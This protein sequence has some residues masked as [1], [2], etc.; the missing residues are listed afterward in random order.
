MQ[1]LRRFVTG[2]LI[3][4]IVVI[5]IPLIAV[6]I[7]CRPF[8]A[9]DPEA[10][11][12]ADNSS[13][14][15]PAI[16]Q[17]KADLS[18]YTRPE[19]QTY[20]TLPEWYIVYSTDEYAVFI[21][22]KLPSRFP[23]FQAIGQ[24]WRSYYEVCGV[25]RTQQYP[26]NTGYHLSLV[27][28][29][30]SF[31]LENTFK[32]LY[33]STVGRFTERISSPAL[34][35]EDF[36]AR[37]VAKEYG[38]FIHTIPW[39]EFPFAARVRQLWQETSLWGPN[40]IRKWERKLALSFEYGVKSGYGWLIKKGTGAAYTPE[41]LLIQAW[42]EG[43]TATILQQYPDFQVVKPISET[44]A[45]VSIPR[46]EAFTQLL[47]KLTDQGVRFVEIAG[48]DEILITAFA[49]S[50]WTYNLDAGTFLFA[51]PVP[52]QPTR[53][54]IAVNVPVSALHRVLADLEKQGIRL[55]HIYDY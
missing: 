4:V 54:R 51:L 10:T 5:V 27:V 38:D 32:G 37:Q 42:A 30:A 22:D 49:P 50:T 2:V 31:T 36:Y 52:T 40:P 26:F 9:P 15:S 13:A 25:T 29:G 34:T 23:Y 20:L 1:R 11:V 7:A 16:Q 41:K 44:V 24:Y 17:I 35:Q 43:V 55:E 19:D 28:I 45:F 12:A 21:I 53:Q 3:L 33:E 18:A 14:T 6:N 47:P 39:Y 46:Y 48:N 8:G